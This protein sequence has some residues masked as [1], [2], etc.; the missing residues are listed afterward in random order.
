MRFMTY[1]VVSPTGISPIMGGDTTLDRY[2]KLAGR[3]S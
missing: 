1:S 3:V 2:P